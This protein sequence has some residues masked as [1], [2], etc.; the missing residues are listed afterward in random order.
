MEYSNELIVVAVAIFLFYL[1]IAMLRGQKKRFEREFALKRRKIKGRSK[2][3]PL[4]QKEPGSPPYGIRS[5]ILVAVAILLMLVGILIRNDFYII[6][7]LNIKL[8]IQGIGW[9][10][11]LPQYWHWFIAAG[12]ILFALCFKIDK[13]I[14]D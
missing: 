2:G 8:Q 6:N 1:R 10:S 12:V 5:W 7:I 3:S 14:E 11:V 9:F 13:P 4:P